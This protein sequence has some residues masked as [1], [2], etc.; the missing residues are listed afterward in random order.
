MSV[1][2][3]IRKGETVE[4]GLRR[5]KKRLLREDIIGTAR[6]NRYFRKPS[7]KKREKTKELKFR[8]MLRRR[9]ADD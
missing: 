8:D 7:E 1:E 3:K 6:L 9:Y 2:V 5:L 4:K